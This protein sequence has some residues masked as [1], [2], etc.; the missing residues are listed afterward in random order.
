M[1]VFKIITHFSRA[2]LISASL[3]Y[4]LLTLVII[5]YN[6]IG[7]AN[8]WE[9]ISLQITISQVQS[10]MTNFKASSL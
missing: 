3:L 1:N 7:L 8:K 10:N 2:P 6:F 5:N 9:I 4:L